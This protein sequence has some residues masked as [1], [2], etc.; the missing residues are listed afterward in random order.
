MYVVSFLDF[1]VKIKENFPF[2]MSSKA[3]NSSFKKKIHPL[4]F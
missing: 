2:Y 4:W 3:I 1:V